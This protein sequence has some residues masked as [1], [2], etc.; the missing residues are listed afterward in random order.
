MA[1]FLNFRIGFFIRLSIIDLVLTNPFFYTIA[2]WDNTQILKNFN[3]SEYITKIDI[4]STNSLI[5][6]GTAYNSI[7]IW[8][9]M[10]NISYGYCGNQITPLKSIIFISRTSLLIGYTNCITFISLLG[11]ESI[12]TICESNFSLINKIML[13]KD[14]NLILIETTQN[15]IVV[16]SVFDKRIL[17]I[18]SASGRIL[19]SFDKN[20]IVCVCGKFDLCKFS[21][22]NDSALCELNRLQNECEILTL[23]II[24]TDLIVFGRSDQKL[25]IWNPEINSSFYYNLSSNILSI[26]VFDKG[27]GKIITSH[28]D[29]LISEWKIEQNNFNF[30]INKT[31][32]KFVEKNYKIEFISFFPFSMSNLISETLKDFLIVT[33][34][35]DC[36]TISKDSYTSEASS[37]DR[38]TSSLPSVL[39]NSSKSNEIIFSNTNLDLIVNLFSLNVDLNDCLSNCS[40]N[41]IC[42]VLDN[43]K[44]KCKCFENYA[45]SSCELKALPCSSNPCLNN[46]S[47]IDDTFGK[48]YSCNC[49]FDINR[50][51]L[52][53]GKNCEYKRNV[54]QNETCSNN[55]ICYDIKNEAKC[56][57]FSKYHGD[58]CQ[59]ESFEIKA[60]KFTIR[61]T[62]IIALII[63]FLFL[64]AFILTDILS[65]IFCVKKKTVRFKQTYREK[66]IYVN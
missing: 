31:R 30:S 9:K 59:E 46:G 52:Y 5:G 64:I 37:F 24:F 32:D 11:S 19:D 17:K 40:G 48:K 28:V 15:K 7:I 6:T 35:F 38:L 25:G 34:A 44:F 42:Q 13:L 60:I 33:K 2:L 27:T 49:L 63:I 58:K 21:L 61:I 8:D 14:D 26:E 10:N 53:Y 47:C 43:F 45:G 41:G 22:S 62:S 66:F 12:V 1:K 23:K 36:S 65:L 16:M 3:S 39:P 18:N 56:K 20:L 50:T 4:D 51:S 57:C 54:C 55:G 29:G